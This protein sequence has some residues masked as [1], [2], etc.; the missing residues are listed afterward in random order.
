MPHITI[1]IYPGQTEEQ[2]IALAQAIT[3]SV[4]EIT[5]KPEKVVS[6]DFIEVPEEAWM[7]EVYE[8]DIRPNLDRLYK[9]PGY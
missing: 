4:I 3:K 5:G 9:K 2:K 7:D 8:T 1:K 6:I